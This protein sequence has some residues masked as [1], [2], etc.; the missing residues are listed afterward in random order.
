M[1]AGLRKARYA[2]R[3]HRDWARYSATVSVWRSPTPRRSRSPAV[4]WCWA[5]E[6]RHLAYGVMSTTPRTAPRRALAR[7][8]GRNDPWAQSWKTMN[9]RTRNPA[10]GTARISVSRTETWTV[11]NIVA[12]SA[13]Y[14]TT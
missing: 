12:I 3:P 5:C 8:E 9:V 7:L 11:A 10:A 13:T 6:W 14:G 4:A 1:I 2:R